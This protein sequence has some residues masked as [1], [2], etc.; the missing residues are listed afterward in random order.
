[1]APIIN[2]IIEMVE[3]GFGVSFIIFS[4]IPRVLTRIPTKY[5][6]P[7]LLFSSLLN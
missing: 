4:K 2:K 1:M 6:I 3:K 5:N 7:L